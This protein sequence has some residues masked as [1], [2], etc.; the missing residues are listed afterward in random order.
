MKK[1]AMI[2]VC[3][4]FMVGAA[5]AKPMKW[6]PR[7]GQNESHHRSRTL[8]RRNR[9]PVWRY[10]TMIN[11]QSSNCERLRQLREEMKEV[12]SRLREEIRDYCEEHRSPES[13]DIC[14]RVKPKGEKG[15]QPW[16]REREEGMGMGKGLGKGRGRGRHRP[17][18]D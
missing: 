9:S 10:C 8:G 6:E 12:K 2:G 11:P 5:S 7:P 15:Y 16:K 3:L 18:R 13:A 17:H 4:M 14:A 1:L